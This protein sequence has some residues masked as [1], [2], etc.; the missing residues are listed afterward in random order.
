MRMEAR[1]NLANSALSPAMAVPST[2]GHAMGPRAELFDLPVPS[3]AESE[4]CVLGC[5]IKN[6]SLFDVHRHELHANLFHHPDHR[7]LF[8][9][10]QRMDKKGTP[11]NVKSLCA[12]FREDGARGFNEVGGAAKLAELMDDATY[13]DVIGGNMVH[14]RFP[15][16]L[17]ALHDANA[18]R[19]Y[20]EKMWSGIQDVHLDKST[21]EILTGKHDELASLVASLGERQA[22]KSAVLVRLDTV[23]PE[24]IEWVWP[25]RIAKG[26]LTVIAG[27]PG[28]GK[29]LVTIDIAARITR[30][31]AWPNNEGQ[32]E[33]GDVIFLSAEDTTRDVI[34]PRLIEASGVRTR[35]KVFEAVKQ[36]DADTGEIVERSFNLAADV[37]VLS[38]VLEANP[39]V[40]LVVI[41]PI[42]S[43]LGGRVDS[44]KEGD[45][46]RVLGPLVTL[47]D[48]YGVA[49]LLVCHLAKVQGRSALSSVMGSVAFGAIARAAW[50][51]THDK[52]EPSRRW[53]SCAKNNL[54]SDQL[55]LGYQLVAAQD[56]DKPAHL[57]WD[58]EGIRATANDMLLDSARGGR[59]RDEVVAWLRDFLA[60]GPMPAA[61]VLKQGMEL[62]DFSESTIRRAKDELGVDVYKD[63][64]GPWMWRLPS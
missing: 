60:V 37:E 3:D 1:N 16:Y 27:E 24:S 54:A 10:L 35:A 58:A 14:A 20:L 22:D 7:K 48:K 55:A 12:A 13:A 62:R 53:M 51:I 52:D 17:A 5:L 45:V 38:G 2:N 46:R 6:P 9:K 30:G 31:D 56:A 23:E 33:Q 63:G 4:A 25:G 61:E 28:T 59:K 18:R 11:I 8:C 21:V 15:E 64:A 39:K 29:S 42:G 34:L 43:Y 47:A 49:V 32:A 36:R 50:L 57:E 44:H 26:K 41:D 19:D 40:R